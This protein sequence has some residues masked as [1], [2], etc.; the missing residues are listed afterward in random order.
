MAVQVSLAVQFGRFLKVG[1]L[2]TAVLYACLWLGVENFGL[3]AAL[4][5][6]IGFM[7]G[8]GVSYGLNSVFTFRSQQAHRRA[9][10]RYAAL[11]AAGW[12]LNGALMLLLAHRLGVNYWLAQLGTSGVVLLWNFIGSRCWVFPPDD[13]T[14]VLPATNPVS[15]RTDP[16]SPPSPKD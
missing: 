11:L 15:S 8:T 3:P 9:A 2:S 6:A 7:L 10:P 13:A 14:L 5:S 1:A 4:A 16:P 12:A